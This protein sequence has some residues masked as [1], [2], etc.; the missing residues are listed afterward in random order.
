M[1]GAV[2]EKV[3]LLPILY[4]R[5]HIEGSTLRSRSVEYQTNLITRYASYLPRVQ[6]YLHLLQI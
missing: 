5:L 2:V 6:D 3:S 1:L 4:K